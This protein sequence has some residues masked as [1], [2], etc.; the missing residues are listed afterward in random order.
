MA[1]KPGDPG[2]KRYFLCS[3]QSIRNKDLH[4]YPESHILGELRRFRD[5]ESWVTALALYETVVPANRVP[6]VNAVIKAY[7]IGDAKLI[8]C[9]YA[10]C[11]SS[12]RWEIGKAGILA[13]MDRLGL[14]ERYLDAEQ[15]EQKHEPVA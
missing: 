13:L 7:I 1:N 14:Q 10:D 15:K 2:E 9:G 12:Q 6:P 4:L 5:G 3:G 11:K 8:R